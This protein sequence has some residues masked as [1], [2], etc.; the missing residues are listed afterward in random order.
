MSNVR[1]HKNISSLRENHR[2]T[3][4]FILSQTVRPST[5][6]IAARHCFSLIKDS[7]QYYTGNLKQNQDFFL[8]QDM[9]FISLQK[10]ALF[11]S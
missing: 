6:T 3:Q 8:L 1:T 4:G 7:I 5:D 9:N 10:Q 2:Y 11:F